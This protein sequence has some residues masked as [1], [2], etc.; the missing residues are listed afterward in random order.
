MIREEDRERYKMRTFFLLLVL[1]SGFPSAYAQTRLPVLRSDQPVVSIQDGENLK[2][3]AWRLAPEVKPDIYQAE[4][5]DGKTQKVTFFS[6][7]DSISFMVEEGKTYDFVIKFEGK[8]AYTRIIGKKFVPA[9]VFDEEYRRIHKGKV[10]VEI[11]E[12]Y[13]MVNVA[14]ALTPGQLKRN[15][16]T[17]GETDYYKSL[18][19][20]FGKHLDHPFLT[21]LNQELIKDGSRYFPLKMDAYSF[22]FDK[23]GRIV[24]SPVYD[25]TSGRNANNLLPYLK[26]M[27]A[28]ADD[29]G[30][31]G[32]YRKNRQFYEGQ[33]SF[34]YRVLDIDEMLRWLGRN[35]PTAK[36]YDSFKIVFSPLVRGNQSVVWF[37]SNGFRELLMHVEFPYRSFEGV[38]EE[39]NLIY[40]GNILFTEMNHG[41]LN[42]ERAK[43]PDEIE[44]ATSNRNFW[45]AKEKG[46]GYYAGNAQVFDEYMNWILVNLRYIDYVPDRDQ[47]DKLIGNI[48]K[49][50]VER[51]GFLQFADFSKFLVEI[52]RN[53][54]PDQTVS[55]LYPQ[56]I[57]WFSERNRGSMNDGSEEH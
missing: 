33:I 54:K 15:T 41:F 40:R 19:P 51:R 57:K 47:Q 16:L 43:Y 37:E 48:D 29:T 3:N 5:I 24:Q 35:F 39:A 50:M 11:P 1:A 55:D 18:L 22:V 42:P 9:A 14:F 27:Q 4:L 2:K 13:E 28:F 56:I 8:E 49:M 6:G 44:S 26:L 45:V 25:R 36:E 52:Y 23:N 30:F 7:I 34:F 12:I 53:R 32:F 20:Y 17:A 31:R 46:P 38:S 10:F 21:A